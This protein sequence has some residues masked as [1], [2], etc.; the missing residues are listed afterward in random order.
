MPRRRALEHE[1]VNVGLIS[2]MLE[3]GTEHTT[4]QPALPGT[5]IPGRFAATPATSRSARG[6]ARGR[7]S[8]RESAVCR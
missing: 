8:A 1:T 5:V 6:A 2:R 7:A 3:R 4:T